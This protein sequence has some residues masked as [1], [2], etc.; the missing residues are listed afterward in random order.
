VSLQ[1]TKVTR[2]SS[3]PLIRVKQLGSGLQ[4][5]YVLP[6]SNLSHIFTNQCDAWQTSSLQTNNLSLT[7]SITSPGTLM[8]VHQYTIDPSWIVGRLPVELKLEIKM[9]TIL[10]QIQ[11]KYPND[12]LESVRAT[13]L[14][15]WKTS[16][17]TKARWLNALV[18]ITI[19]FANDAHG[20]SHLSS[21]LAYALRPPDR[22]P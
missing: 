9:F 12:K 20:R 10:M 7:G 13:L 3:S 21:T 17:K 19:L 8:D 11:E 18:S 4:V 1:Y 14:R 5:A 15:D 22:T 16:Y 2:S 6:R